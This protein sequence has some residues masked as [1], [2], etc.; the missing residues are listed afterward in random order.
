MFSTPKKSN[1]YIKS[2]LFQTKL[3]KAQVVILYLTIKSPL[4]YTHI[5]YPTILY[6]KRLIKGYNNT[7]SQ[8]KFFSHDSDP[9]LGENI[10]H[11]LGITG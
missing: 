10:L 2:P 4:F 1:F 5:L 6:Q 7:E 3:L 9:N 11:H 8:K